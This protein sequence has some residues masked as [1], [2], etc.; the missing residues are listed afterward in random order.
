MVSGFGGQ[1]WKGGWNM[2]GHFSP[3]GFPGS[4]QEVSLCN[5][6]R[7]LFEYLCL[8]SRCCA[9]LCKAA[10]P[11][12]LMTVPL[13]QKAQVV[14]PALSIQRSALCPSHTRVHLG[15]LACKLF[16]ARRI[17][18]CALAEHLTRWFPSACLLPPCRGW[19]GPEEERKCGQAPS[20]CVSP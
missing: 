5:A 16:G 17:P 9:P 13:M 12:G 11:R 19:Q 10:F 7:L 14:F 4:V 6:K 15:W 8:L 20:G 3:R 18:L 1:T 2:Q